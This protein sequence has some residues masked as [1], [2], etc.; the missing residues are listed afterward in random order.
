[1]ARIRTIK[2]EFPQSESIGRLSRDARLLF[3][4]LWT[5][6]DDS[7]RARAASRML[8][9]LLYPYD[10]DAPSLIEGWLSELEAA[11]CIRRY[12]ADG[13][14]YLDIP[15]WLEHQK[16][17]RPTASKLPGYR[18]GSSNPREGSRGLVDGPVPGPG[19]VRDQDAAPARAS[20]ESD[21]ASLYRRGKEI[22]GGNSGGMIKKLVVA[23]D[24]NVALARAAVEMAS[25]KGDP[26]D[27]IGAII[28]NR[29]HDAE[30]R[31]RGDAW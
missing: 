31:A 16:I 13:S 8:A 18:E 17:D 30:L 4:Q 20:D 15:K 2:P 28:R 1:M 3:V 10:D 19:P 14:H 9:S 5:I 23:K 24:G 12:E 22:L 26:R 7:G 11:G 21:E 27:Y 25:T 6:V 29:D